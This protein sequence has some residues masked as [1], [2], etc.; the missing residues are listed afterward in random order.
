MVMHC[1]CAL[2]GEVDACYSTDVNIGGQLPGAD[3][4]FLPVCALWG[5]IW[6]GQGGQQAAITSAEPSHQPSLIC[7]EWFP[8]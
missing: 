7:Y 1:V 2:T 6:S 3:C 8:I 5:I 4:F